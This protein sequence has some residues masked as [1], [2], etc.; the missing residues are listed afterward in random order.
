MGN[1]GRALDQCILSNLFSFLANLHNALAFQ[2]IEDHIH[3]SDVLLQGLAR[4]QGDVHDLGHLCI[5]QI[6]HI[7]AMRI[8]LALD[9]FY[10]DYFHL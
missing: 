8:W 6:P 5:A 3:G 2:H 4:L 7:Y 10:N 9:I 1:P